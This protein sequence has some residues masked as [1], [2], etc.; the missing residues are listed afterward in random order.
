MDLSVVIPLYNESESIDELNT[1]INN[2]L[3]NSGLDYE[4]IYVDDGSVDSSW[5]KIKD[6]SAKIKNKVSAYRFLK[7]YGKSMALSAG[8]KKIKRRN[9]NNNG[10]R[11]TR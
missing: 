1:S 8:F 7:N 11:F 3:N 4:L 6:I 2:I 5:E 10:C 9:C